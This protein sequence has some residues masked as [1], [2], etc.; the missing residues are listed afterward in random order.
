MYKLTLSILCHFIFCHIIFDS[1]T[2]YCHFSLLF[3]I[4]YSISLFKICPYKHLHFIHKIHQMKVNKNYRPKKYIVLLGFEQ[5]RWNTCVY[6]VFLYRCY[7]PQEALSDFSLAG[8][9]PSSEL[10]PY[11]VLT[12]ICLMSCLFLPLDYE[13]LMA[14]I[15][16]F[17]Q[18]NLRHI[19]GV[20]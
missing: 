13:I 5:S 10:P 17:S 4:I 18:Q 1:C 3:L 12:Q 7:L 20:S 2:K 11:P 19:V 15:L 9:G 8:L 14:R 6:L 16:Y